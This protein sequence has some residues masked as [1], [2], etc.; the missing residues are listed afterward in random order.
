MARRIRFSVL[1]RWKNV[2]IRINLGVPPY[3]HTTIV[4][5]GP[6][7]EHQLVQLAGI[8]TNVRIEIP[9]LIVD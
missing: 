1:S 4:L 9:S 5:D 8:T 3:D 2:V 7:L 6:D